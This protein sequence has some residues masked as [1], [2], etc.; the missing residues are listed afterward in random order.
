MAF[1]ESPRFPDN[2]SYGSKG[3]P[4]FNTVITT[5]NSGFEFN[6][7]NW[8]Q[9]RHSYDV[10]MGV[11]DLQEL[12]QLVSFFQI[13]RGRG[14]YFR[15]KD[16]FD[17]KS[18]AL[19]ELI[20]S[21]DQTFGIGD[22]VTTEFYL[23]KTYDLSGGIINERFITKPVNGTILI[24]VNAILLTEDTYTNGISNNDN[25]YWIDYTSG[26]VTFNVAPADTTSIKWGGEFDVPCRF[27]VDQLELS[28]DFYGHGSTGIPVI[29]VR[30]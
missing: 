14:H 29:E 3:G 11:R 17:Y 18:C 15:Y 23:L 1:I 2:I 4:K 10:A 24:E 13:V 27:D 8:D 19:D 9:A 12:S 26:K 28:M 7:I 6:N 16:W 20:S 30:V 21:S 22:G 25:D 5:V